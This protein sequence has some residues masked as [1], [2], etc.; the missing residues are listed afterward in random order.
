MESPSITE[1]D[2]DN[3]HESYQIYVKNE[4]QE[5]LKKKDFQVIFDFLS[6]E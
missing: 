1:L 5:F 6:S 2:Y 4:I 3:D